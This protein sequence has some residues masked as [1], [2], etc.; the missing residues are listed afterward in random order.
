MGRS[1]MFLNAGP[2]GTGLSYRQRLDGGRQPA[3]SSSGS[4]D[5]SRPIRIS[6]QDD[7]ALYIVDDTGS[8]I[9]AAVA[10][11]VKTKAAEKLNQYLTDCLSVHVG[12]PRPGE[13]AGITT[14]FFDANSDGADVS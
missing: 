7:G 2:P 8:P 5:Y 9:P 11:R 3:S 12:A 14:S 6:V 4:S 1:G 13:S 10:R